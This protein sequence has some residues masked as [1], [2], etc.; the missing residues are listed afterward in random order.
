MTRYWRRCGLSAFF[1]RALDCRV[2]GPLDDAQFDHFA[3][4]KT[5][6][7]AR[8][9][10]RRLRA[11]E[12]DQSCL[13]RP[14]EY[15]AHRRPGPRLAAQHGLEA[16]L[17]K[18]LA[19]PMNRRRIGSER[20]DDAAVAPA[21]AGFRYVPLQEDARLGQNLRPVLALT[22]HRLQTLALLRLEPHHITLHRRR[23]SRHSQPP[24][25]ESRRK[26]IPK[27][28]PISPKR[29]TRGRLACCSADWTRT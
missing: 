19:R 15:L 12:R 14:V 16:F 24:S 22:H 2:A 13:R 1:E 28:L 27:S 11:G 6:A 9:A 17:H 4:Q 18:L 5:Q 20:L 7:P 26:R 29:P 3:L 21:L 25:C 23:L 10:L 8:V